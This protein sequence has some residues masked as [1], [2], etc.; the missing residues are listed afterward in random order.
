MHTTTRNIHNT[1]HFCPCLSK[2]KAEVK[3][4]L[5]L[6]SEIKLSAWL[7]TPPVESEWRAVDWKN[8]SLTGEAWHQGGSALTT[9]ARGELYSPIPQPKKSIHCAI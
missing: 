5:I 3:T 6:N 2:Q 7:L 1:L 8:T 9:Q 4:P